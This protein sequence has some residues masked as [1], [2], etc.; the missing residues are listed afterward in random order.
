MIRQTVLPFKIERTDE[1][2]TA[3]SELALY[4]EFMKGMKLAELVDR[5]MPSP[6]S[7]RTN[8]CLLNRRLSTL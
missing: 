2:V 7:G 5:H 1:K 4:G 8:R 6:R 3:R